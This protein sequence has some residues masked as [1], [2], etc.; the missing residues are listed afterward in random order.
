M[1]FKEI[2]DQVKELFKEDEH[3]CNEEYEKCNNEE[4]SEEEE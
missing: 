2:K 1:T 4:D 3:N